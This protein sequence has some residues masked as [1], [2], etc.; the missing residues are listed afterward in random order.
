MAEAKTMTEAKAVVRS[1]AKRRKPKHL[2]IYSPA[3]MTKRVFLPM[4][5]IGDNTKQILETNLGRKMEGRCVVEGYVKEGSVKVESYSS[6]MLQ[7]D[8][9]VFEVI[10]QCLVCS[11]V[12]GMNIRC[13][14]TNITETAGIKA[15]S[16]DDPSPV[17]IYV[18]RDHNFDNKDYSRVKVGDTIMTRVIGQR[19]E[20]NDPYISIIAELIEDKQ[21]KYGKK[22]LK[23]QDE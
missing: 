16:E 12:E 11:P 3:I 15:Q 1:V 8:G 4:T 7:D 13:V 14:V 20:L 5:S 23:I 2:G 9:A 10:I 17:I 18:A 6:G 22:K 21:A 19:F